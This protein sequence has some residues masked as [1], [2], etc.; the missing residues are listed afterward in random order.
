M[1]LLEFKCQDSIGHVHLA[2]NLSYSA[3]FFSRNSIFCHKNQLT[4]FFSQLIIPAERGQLLRTEKRLGVQCGL[5]VIST[6][7]TI[8]NRS[9][10][11]LLHPSSITRKS[12]YSILTYRN[13]IY[14]YYFIILHA[15]NR[16]NGYLSKHELYHTCFYRIFFCTK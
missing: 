2:Y 1:F 15:I 9:K 7:A 10:L 13:K 11:H 6:F 4:V 3:C 12:P 5:S 14:R 8:S 16:Q